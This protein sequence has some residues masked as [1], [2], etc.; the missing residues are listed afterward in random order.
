MGGLKL[1]KEFPISTLPAGVGCVL[2]VVNTQNAKSRKKSIYTRVVICLSRPA[3]KQS[4]GGQDAAAAA[5]KLAKEQELEQKVLEPRE[6]E[7]LI[8]G[9]HDAAAG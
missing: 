5:A 3:A 8:R 9:H 2:I 6:K 1:D 7:P 4:P